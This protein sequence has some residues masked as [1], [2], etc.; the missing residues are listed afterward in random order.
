MQSMHKALGAQN[1]DMHFASPFAGLGQYSLEK[2][3]TPLDTSALP[4]TRA[5]RRN[6]IVACRRKAHERVVGPPQAGYAG[7]QFRSNMRVGLPWQATGQLWRALP[8][9]VS[10]ARYRIH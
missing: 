2:T 9:L 10:C 1:E 4:Y 7:R 6:A 8:E 3:L 5:M